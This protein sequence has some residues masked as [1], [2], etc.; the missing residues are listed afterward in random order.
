[1]YGWGVFH[2]GCAKMESETLSV[3]LIYLCW[4]QVSIRG[5]HVNKTFNGEKTETRDNC[6]VPTKEGNC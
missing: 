4:L 1:M 6:E 5:V 2:E 3:I